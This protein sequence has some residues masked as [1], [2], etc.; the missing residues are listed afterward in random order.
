MSNLVDLD[1]IIEEADEIILNKTNVEKTSMPEPLVLEG[2]NPAPA[3]TPPSLKINIKEALELIP[4]AEKLFDFSGTSLNAHQQTYIVAYAV[5]GTRTR[6]AKIAGVP[7]RIVKEWLN[8]EEFSEALVTAAEVVTDVLEEE[9]IRRA[10]EGSDKLLLE[11]LKARKT[12]YQPKSS[13]NVNVTGEIV[14]TWSELAKQ[15]N[16]YKP[17]EV[18]DYTEVK[19]DDD[20]D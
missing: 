8:D 17:I 18:T 6:A 5:A 15:A 14:H 2:V 9:L 19:D 11:A 7:Y 1:L 13:Q 12:A 3:P 10:M 4:D 16:T 20:N